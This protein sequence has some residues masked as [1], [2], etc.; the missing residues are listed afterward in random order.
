MVLYRLPRPTPDGRT[1]LRLSPLEFLDRLAAL[2]PPP[3]V[4]RHRYHG[5]LAPNSPLRPRVTASTG[6]AAALPFPHT[7]P[8]RPVSTLSRRA[9]R[10]RSR[11]LSSRWAALLARIHHARPLVCPECGEAMRL[12]AFLTDPF[13]I[14][15]V[16]KHLGEPL[17]PPPVR[18]ARG[19]PE[20]KLGL[21][22]ASG[23]AMDQTP[24]VDPTE[25]E[26]IPPYE[27]DQTRSG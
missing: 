11:R 12:I 18:P 26:P 15:D 27:M 7:T 2:L 24:A 23:D 20:P 19:P 10:S 13:S 3:R 6:E 22:A 8:P 14:R 16:L 17:R 21:A 5:V 25:P 4:H 1:V 9:A